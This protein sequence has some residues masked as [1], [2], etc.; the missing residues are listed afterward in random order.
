MSASRLDTFNQ[1]AEAVF[2][3]QLENCGYVL[4]QVKT[5]EHN[6]SPWSVHHIYLNQSTGLQVIL[7]QEP[8]YTDYGFSFCI[9]KAGTTEY[10]ILYNVP[11][12]KQD[13]EGAFIHK[14]AD[15]LFADT[16]MVD[17]IGGKYWKELGNIPFQR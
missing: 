10:N 7:K 8:Y 5:N 17:M 2:K 11:H 16:E 1:I 3:P 13:L 9:Y 6:G 4:Q 12:E 14:A 15:E